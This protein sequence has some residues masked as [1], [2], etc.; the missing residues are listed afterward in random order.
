M[1]KWDVLKRAERWAAPRGRHES[2][3]KQRNVWLHQKTKIYERMEGV[4]EV[5]GGMDYWI[6]LLNGIRRAH[7]APPMGVK[8]L[9]A[10]GA[11]VSVH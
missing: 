8:S 10:I 4:H 9:R 5:R 2:Y 7:E 3:I 1:V 11:K 6:R